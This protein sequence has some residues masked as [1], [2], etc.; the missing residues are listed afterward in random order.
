MT[1][2]MH[3]ENLRSGEPDAALL[4]AVRKLPEAE[5]PAGFRAAVLR[6]LQ[7]KRLPWWRRAWLWARTPRP[8]AVTPLRLAG[9]ALAAGLL[10]LAALPLLPRPQVPG[11]ET[12]AHGLQSV[13]FVLPDPDGRMRSAAVIGTFNRWNPKGFEMHFSP[14]Q[15]AWL[16]QTSLAAGSHE[17]VFLLDGKQLQPDPGAAL[18]KDDG[19]GNSNS[20]LLLGNGHEQKL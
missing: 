3:D 17:Y 13:T 5:P 18:T 9:A 11:G 6:R 7:P 4:Q 16:L 19:F 2:R 8:L 15:R 10:I 14:E 20:V 1:E 12:P